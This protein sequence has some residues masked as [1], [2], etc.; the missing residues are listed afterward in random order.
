MLEEESRMLR[1]RLDIIEKRL[2]ELKK[3]A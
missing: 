2:E 3:E 1:E